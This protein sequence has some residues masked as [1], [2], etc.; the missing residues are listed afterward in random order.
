[1][2][3]CTEVLLVLSRLLPDINPSRPAPV[4]TVVVFVKATGRFCVNIVSP[5]L[6][7][8]LKPVDEFNLNKYVTV[9]HKK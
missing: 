3:A 4:T 1:M 7:V 5:Y 2:C 9:H 8:L 6:S